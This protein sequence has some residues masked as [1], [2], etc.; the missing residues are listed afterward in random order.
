MDMITDEVANEPSLRAGMPIN[1]P[2][3]AVAVL[4]IGEI[5]SAAADYLKVLDDRSRRVITRR[6]GLDGKKPLTLHAIGQ[7]ENVTR[8]R[9]RQ[10]EQTVLKLFRSEK[11]NATEFSGVKK[12]QEALSQ[13]IRFLGGVAREELIC[14]LLKI[15]TEADRAALGFLMRCLPSVVE[16]RESSR[17]K[18][19]FQHD[20]HVDIE[21]IVV[22]A[23]A[24]LNEQ[25]RL[26]S[27]AD[28]FGKI[29]ERCVI[30]TPNHVLYSVLMITHDLVRT[31]F[32]EWGIR[33]W[34]EATPRGVGDKA[35]VVLKRGDK[36][37]HFLQITELI[38][39]AKYD[40][41]M[42][43]AQTVHN[44]LI[45][46][47]RFVLVGRGMYALREWGYQT[48]TVGDVLERIIKKSSKAMLKEELV[49]EVLK[50]RI[51][52]RNTI[53]L[54]LQNRKL[55]TH[56]EQ[57]HFFLVG[58]SS[59][60]VEDGSNLEKQKKIINNDETVK[61]SPEREESP[62]ASKAEDLTGGAA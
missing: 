48:G 26:F 54:A 16:V 6:F 25:K 7:G 19:F 5:R 42:A 27:D 56:D 23:R 52:K 55:F 57:G 18:R 21:K 36:P 8:E 14:D 17:Y 10:V 32:G 35:Y 38:N 59:A 29:R 2:T 47:E 53:L 11:R 20:E 50:E 44:E 51:V 41:R 4:T 43:H 31:P 49:D 28:L 13:I 33:G 12:V 9:I 37:L 24:V 62:S 58:S 22:A 45:R 1:L 3:A 40:E 60:A 46:D 34:V 30:N 39:T 15:K 61:T